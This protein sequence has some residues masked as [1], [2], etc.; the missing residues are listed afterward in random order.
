MKKLIKTTLYA[1][2][3]GASACAGVAYAEDEID[4]S[5]YRPAP[6]DSG[7]CQGDIPIELEVH[8]HCEVKVGK[9]IMLKED[10]S[11]SSSWFTVTTNV[12]YKL[13]LSTANAGDSS[14]TFVLHTDGLT[15]IPTKIETK[16]QGDGMIALGYSDHDGI[17]TD[18]FNVS[19]N[20]A[21]PVSSSQKF[22]TYKDLYK[23]DVSY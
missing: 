2:V 16:K 6:C 10:G 21:S 23:I 22:G 7:K 12:P 14:S 4:L 3:V 20:T 1:L 17:T 5:S 19:V 9:D 8:K 11:K 15:K 18:T 13:H